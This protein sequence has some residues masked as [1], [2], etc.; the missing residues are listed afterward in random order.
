MTKVLRACLSM[1]AR[2]DHRSKPFQL[3]VN[4]LDVSFVKHC[5]L[6][7]LIYLRALNSI[8]FL[9]HFNH[10]G[11]RSICCLHCFNLATF[12]CISCLKSFD[13][14]SFSSI[15]YLECF[16]LSSLFS[17]GVCEHLNLFCLC[18]ICVL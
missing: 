18:C 10:T 8:S 4:F 3:T 16:D 14:V 13:L 2:D 12:C 5:I 6:L 9:K 1:C 7:Q 17:I 11:L 15:G